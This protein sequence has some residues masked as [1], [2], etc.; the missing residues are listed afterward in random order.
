MYACLLM[1][2]NKINKNKNV[3]HLKKT[4]TKDGPDQRDKI[5]GARLRARRNL[6]KL[7]Q[8]ELGKA[9]GLT[10]QQIQKYEHGTNKISAG[11]IIDFSEVLNTPINFFF[12]GLSRI[13]E[14]TPKALI[15]S[16]IA[17][18]SLDEDPLTNKE[19]TAL[20]RAY[21]AITDEKKRKNIL[22]LIK[23]MADE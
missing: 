4:K 22:N 16:D 20:V 10:F 2:L 19:T 15:V 9:V 7:S 17:Q 18:D 3:M 6:L 12:A 14:K 1:D 13:D 5:I 8:T 21:Y 11:R 23:S